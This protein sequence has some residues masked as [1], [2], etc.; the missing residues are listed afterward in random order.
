MGAFDTLS[1]YPLLASSA[2][3][4]DFKFFAVVDDDV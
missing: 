1:A 4:I 2:N 3:N